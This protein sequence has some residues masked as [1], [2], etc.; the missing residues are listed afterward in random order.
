MPER[1]DLVIRNGSIFDGSG[2]PSKLVDIGVSGE[3]I[4][5]IGTIADRGSIE[6]DATGLAVTP[7][8]IDVHSHDD[9][10][11]L[12][13]PEFR[14]KTL[15]GVTTDIVGNC[16]SGA[17]PFGLNQIGGDEF[18]QL[19]PWLSPLLLLSGPPRCGSLQR[20]SG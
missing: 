3:R 17:A 12:A 1:Y 10:A 19:A 20:A 2:S 14:C 16:G 15:Q 4:R 11:V 9:W 13:D 18:G 8:F 5:T 7:G 6:I